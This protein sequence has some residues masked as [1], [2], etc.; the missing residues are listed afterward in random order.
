[1]L[2]GDWS[3]DVCSSDLGVREF[4]VVNRTLSRAEELVARVGGRAAPL[5]QLG[6]LLPEADLVLTATSSREALIDA[7]MAREA[8]RI[9]RGRRDRKSV[10]EGKG[11]R[12]G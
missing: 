9:R 1:R 3:S 12:R 7:S 5:P 6:R 10:V 11:V 8:S 4:T 2:Q